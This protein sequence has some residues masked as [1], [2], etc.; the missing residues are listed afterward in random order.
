MYLTIM[1]KL[2]AKV[3]RKLLTSVFDDAIQFSQGLREPS[4]ICLAV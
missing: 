1:Y 2:T 3:E 4:D